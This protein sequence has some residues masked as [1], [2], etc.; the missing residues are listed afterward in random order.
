[1][2][3]DGRSSIKTINEQKEW[4]WILAWTCGASALNVLFL[5]SQS[6]SQAT[7]LKS[8]IFTI[9]ILGLTIVGSS[10]LLFLNGFWLT[11][12]TPLFSVTVSGI[13]ISCYCQLNQE[14][15]QKKLSYTD[16]L[17]KIPNRRFFDEFLNKQWQ[18]HKTQKQSLSVILGDVDFFKKYN[19][20]YGHQAGDLCLQKV[21]NVLAQSVRKGD[22]AARYGGEEFVAV[23]PN[24]PPDV[25]IKIAQR[26]CDRLKSLQ[27]D[28]ASSQAS[29]YVSI[30]FGIA[31]TS[32]SLVQ[33]PE[34]LMECAD[35]ALYLAKEQGRDRAVL[36]EKKFLK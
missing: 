10:Y 21:G 13:I 29:E 7:V 4:L 26:I 33:S 17:T 27:I 1:M 28:H 35:K 31:C 6:N 23:L 9:F 11:V 25:A 34:E 15:L 22:L 24:T 16:G 30:S 8:T 5:N 14:E 18:K 32:V 12:I 3:L 2:A 36:W 20:T 19:D